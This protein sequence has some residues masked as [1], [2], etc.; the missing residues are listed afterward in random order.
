MPLINIIFTTAQQVVALLL[1]NKKVM[2][3]NPNLYLSMGA[4]YLRDAENV[5][6]MVEFNKQNGVYA[7]N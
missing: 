1:C 6:V 4:C 7:I 2:S 3:S 5:E